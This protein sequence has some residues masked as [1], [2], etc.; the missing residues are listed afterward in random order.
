MVVEDL[1]RET[2]GERTEL[3]GR[4][5][6]DSA[7]EAPERIWFRFPP[8][9]ANGEVD[10]SPFLP[11]LL[12]AAMCLREDLRIDAPV[13]ER[14]LAGAEQAQLV[15]RTWWPKLGTARVEAEPARLPGGGESRATLF[16]RGADSWHTVLNESVDVL[17]YSAAADF[18]WGRRDSGP[19]ETMRARASVVAL[20][21][22]CA[23]RRGRRLVVVDTNLRHFVEPLRNWGFSHG[24]ILAACGLAVGS[25]IREL[26]IPSSLTYGNLTQLGTHPLLDPCWSTERTVVIHDAPEV[27]RIKKL[28]GVA[29]DR[30]A[31]EN[32]L[33]CNGPDPRLNCCRCGMCLSTMVQLE[34]IGVLDRAVTFP[35]PLRAR[36]VAR[37]RTTSRLSRRATW[38]HIE[39]VLSYGGRASLAAALEVG[40]LRYHTGRLARLAYRIARA[41][42]RRRGRGWPRPR[43]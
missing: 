26:R 30:N 43:S 8:D 14:L 28:I 18:V 4:L 20:H 24:G 7:V 31:F 6:V 42:V 27:R 12:L 23:E 33:V 35:A 36:D 34:A 5:R 19:E 2:V 21:R 40:L 38:L 17:L 25:G 29:A 39:E 15:M 37:L 3:S 16:T 32:L 9:L 41:A 22:A 1:R 13:S 10:G 11:G